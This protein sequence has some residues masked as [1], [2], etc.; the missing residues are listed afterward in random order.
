[1]PGDDA[2]ALD[3]R[4]PFLARLRRRAHAFRRDERG[5]TLIEFG[6]LAVPFF[7]I[8]AATL[9]TALIF[10]AAQILDSA[11][12]DSARLIR[13]GQAQQASYTAANF[14]TAI[15]NGLFGMFDCTQLKVK[16]SIVADFNA[17]ATPVSPVQTG[18][19]C[20]PNCQWTIVETYTP[21]SGSQVIMVQAFYKWPVLI[22]FLGF[23]LKN[24]PDGTRL[25][26]AVR[27]FQNE[28][29]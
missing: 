20:S 18:A 11:V 24:Q 12:Q 5:V 27:V 15:C 29:F 9:E 22:N 25:L 1:V 2:S 23:N 21:G 3:Q 19:A 14:R 7:A 17:A 10:F 26:G 28:P 4:A 13:T 6:I 16:V 8:I